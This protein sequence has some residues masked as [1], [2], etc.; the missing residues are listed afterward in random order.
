[1]RL[2]ADTGLYAVAV[3]VVQ[4]E[5]AEFPVV[6]YTVLV[7]AFVPSLADVGVPPGLHVDGSLRARLLVVSAVLAALSP[8]ASSFPPAALAVVDTPVTSFSQTPAF[9]TPASVIP[10]ARTVVSLTLASLTLVFPV[11]TFDVR[12][13]VAITPVVAPAL[14]AAA[15][16]IVVVVDLVAERQP[17]M[18][19][20]IVLGDSFV[21]QESA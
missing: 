8:A 14:F 9:P 15:A 19:A 11:Q 10:V 4:N 7:S 12:V 17:T 13:P 5:V 6:V 21:L 20:A 3:V 16:G 18:A 2:H 1:V